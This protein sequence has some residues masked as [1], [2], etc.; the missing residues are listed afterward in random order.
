MS[1]TAHLTVVAASL[2][3][4]MAV[5]NSCFGDEAITAPDLR[6]HFREG[7]PLVALV[8]DKEALYDPQTGLFVKSNTF[9]R[10]RDWERRGKV[11]YYEDEQ[12]LFS[13]DVGVRLHGGSTRHRNRQKRVRLYFRDDYGAVHFEPQTLLGPDPSVLRTVVVRTDDQD[14]ACPLAFDI[15][16]RMGAIVP[17]T[18]PVIFVLNGKSLGQYYLTEHLSRRRW[19]ALL[20]H[21]DFVVHRYKSED[22]VSD[23][24]TQISE[25]ARTTP[26]LTPQTVNERVDLDN[27]TRHLLS[28]VFCATN[29]WVQGAA[30]LDKRQRTPRWVWVNW[31]MDHSFV[32]YGA[33]W[34]QGRR[35]RWRQ[36]AFELL[37]SHHNFR[38]KDNAEQD[39]TT[40]D[41]RKVL[42]SRLWK[43][44]PAYRADV[45]KMMTDELN[46][47]ITP[48]LLQA[49]LAYY[50]D[51]LGIDIPEPRQEFMRHRGEFIR[52]ELQRYFD[53]GPEVNVTV[54][55]PAGVLLEVDGFAETSPYEGTYFAGQEVTVGAT[56][57]SRRYGVAWLVN[58]Q[59]HN[60][61][62]LSV[63]ADFD[64]TIEA[65]IEPRPVVTL[66][67][68]MVAIVLLVAVVVGLRIMNR[69]P[70]SRSP[71]AD[72]R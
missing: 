65:L 62:S 40:G 39:I 24:Y 46:H 68:I 38:K 45:L 34:K 25:W 71:D 41:L 52:E 13:S 29:D 4:T 56:A 12:L 58:G 19:R 55:A 67:R 14:F 6:D 26:H 11:F 60:G 10:G 42:F 53:A 20:G 7:W 66:S 9:K 1:K 72:E 48:E 59:T 33:S 43:D 2:A 15:S 27:L 28:I 30:V 16:R 32:D 51:D 31:D 8:I 69:S 57:A 5:P 21:R 50:Q 44:S 64:L 23:E 37:F 17:G 61:S 36:E 35:P 18:Q 22:P 3:A 54:T 70:N 49:K 47:H 63:Q